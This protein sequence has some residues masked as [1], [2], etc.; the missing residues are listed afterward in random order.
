MMSRSF[1]VE[2]MSRMRLD[3]RMGSRVT[4]SVREGVGA[5]ALVWPKH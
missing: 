3:R 1:L 4:Q 2:A 5:G